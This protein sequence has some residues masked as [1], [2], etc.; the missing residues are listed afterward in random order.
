MAKDT[1]DIATAPA[2]NGKQRKERQRK[3]I[4]HETNAIASVTAALH[5]LSGPARERVMSYVNSRLAEAQ[6]GGVANA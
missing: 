1:K 4:D 5:P 2:V 6:S 3:P